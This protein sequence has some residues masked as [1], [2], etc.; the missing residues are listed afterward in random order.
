MAAKQTKGSGGP[1]GMDADQFRRILCSKNFNKEGK[2]LREELADFEKNISCKL[3]N[4][5][6]LEAYVSCRLIPLDKAPGIRLIGVGEVLRRVVGKSISRVANKVIKEA[7]GP[8]QTCAG[9]GAGAEA[10]IHAMR[11]M[12]TQEG[13]DGVLLIDASNAFNSMNRSVALHNIQ[14]ICPTIA[15]YL[16]NTQ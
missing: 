3:Y 7:A 12:F 6:L 4:P 14:I 13:V 9:H 5:E 1:S 10:A 11:E 8:L 16:L 2:A 15:T